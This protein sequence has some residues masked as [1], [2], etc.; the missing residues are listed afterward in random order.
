MRRARMAQAAGS[1]GGRLL[2]MG[3]QTC[4]MAPLTSCW[5]AR[6]MKR[7]QTSRTPR[8][9]A[10]ARHPCSASESAAGRC[11]SASTCRAH[12]LVLD[13]SRVRLEVTM[14]SYL[15]MCHLPASVTSTRLF[16][17]AQEQSAA[18]SSASDDDDEP[19]AAASLRGSGKR[20]R[21]RSAQPGRQRSASA[22]SRGPNSRSDSRS[23]Q[24]SRVSNGSAAAAG[25]RTASGA[26]GE[27][28]GGRGRAASAQ[29]RRPPTAQRASNGTASAASVGP[30]SRRAQPRAFATDT[31]GDLGDGGQPAPRDHGKLA[32]ATGEF[33][34]DVAPQ[35]R[36]TT[37]S[38][39]PATHEHGE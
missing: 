35:P 38:A 10:P 9:A 37:R 33:A 28:S 27:R 13:G 32:A 29:P 34:G 3:M 21:S 2:P 14:P 15:T 7:D 6:R 11:P 24:R 36:R 20:Q 30:A 31:R 25:G 5:A 18:A 12:S 26:A 23:R 4:P 8:T 22:G 17:C 16:C 1:G 39:G 19:L